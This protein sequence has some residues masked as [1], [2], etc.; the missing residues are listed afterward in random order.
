[1]K[2]FLSLKMIISLLLI[3]LIGVLMLLPLGYTQ[4]RDTH[5]DN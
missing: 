3:P 5:S 2:N 1:M 4:E